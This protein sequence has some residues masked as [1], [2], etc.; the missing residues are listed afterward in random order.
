[1]GGSDVMDIAKGEALFETGALAEVE[2]LAHLALMTDLAPDINVRW[3]NLL[4]FC[5]A[6]QGKPTEA[7]AVFTQLA[8][9]Q[10]GEASHRIN[11][12]N[13]CLE[14]GHPRE[15]SE[16]FEQARKLGA[17]GVAY[18]LGHGLALMAC[19]QFEPASERLADAHALE[20]EA[21]DVRLAYAQCLSE[22]ENFD[23]VG[24]LVGQ[25][26]EAG[27]V[28]DQQAVLAWLLAQAGFDER[29]TDLYRRL[30]ETDPG[31]THLRVQLALLL[32]RLNRLDDARALLANEP[33]NAE[34]R[35]AMSF[36]AHGR[37]GR[38][39]GDVER[40]T[41]LLEQGLEV[42]AEGAMQAQLQ[43]ELAK[44]HD[45]AGDPDACMATLS[46]AHTQAAVAFAQRFP[47]VSQQDVLGWLGERL[48][49]DAPPEW[50]LQAPG[51]SGE[52]PVFLVG[53][54]RSGTTLLERML[55]A[56]PGLEVLD[57]RP[58]LEKSI[59]RLKRLPGWRGGALDD[60]LG[61][62]S[63]SDLDE[64]RQAYW[65]EVRRYLVPRGRLV[66]KYPLYMTRVPYV[67]RLFPRA[68]WLLMLRH[69]CD[70]V[71]S[72]HMQAFGF[73][74]GAL[75]FR[76]LE[77]TA[78]AYADM[79]EHW[80]SQLAKV[81]MS[82]H[83]LR[84]EDLIADFH[85]EL[86]RAMAFLSLKRVAGQDTFNTKAAQRDRRINTPSYSQVIRPVNA[87][88]VGRWRRYRQHFNVRTLALLEPWIRRYGYSLD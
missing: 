2:R 72:C 5:L 81:S 73:N 7:L 58:A 84:Y 33:D 61:A 77:S 26:P 47:Q 46:A 79:M 15:A 18:L 78:E 83:V 14:A 76:S 64:A 68:A 82:A 56:H 85:G 67:A 44:C 40:A 4:A 9:L 8:R 60:A 66:D 55:D 32:E 51:A 13:A 29:A 69:P 37:L 22:L 31:A 70:C 52:D 80:T 87:S 65:H 25:L 19:A 62:L 35:D 36:L 6:L 53:F 30:I 71:L 17:E 74:G 39:G 88:A 63:P 20:P 59:A 16:A 57:E 86:D 34:A 1:M 23:A 12:G 49:H 21:I 45:Q 28:R 27:L 50:A 48:A 41:S 3:L 24:K 43:F 54:P 10:P 38:R 75:V 42:A 11:L